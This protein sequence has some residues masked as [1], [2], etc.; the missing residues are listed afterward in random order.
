MLALV[1]DLSG[2]ARSDSVADLFSHAFTTLVRA[3]PFDAGVAAMLE[4]DLDLYVSSRHASRRVGEPLI[5][6][7][8]GALREV[9]PSDFANVDIIVKDERQSLPAD[10]DGELT[11]HVHSILR[12]ENRTVGFVLVTRASAKFNED[13]HRVVDIF[14]AQLS[15]LLDN[16]RARE[17][18][19]S[20]ADIDD[21][22][23]IPNRRHFRRQLTSEM[24]RARV[25]NEPLSVLIID[26][27]D[28]K[29]INDT[30]GHVMGDVVLSELCGTI[31]DSVRVPD[32]V[33]RFGGDEFAV[34]LPHTSASGAAIVADRILKS[35]QEMSIH[36]DEDRP[37]QC[38]VSVGIAQCES[39][40]TNFND[41]VRRA[42]ACL[43]DSKRH[44]KNRYTL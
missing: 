3:I 31:R 9:I 44:G 16:L 28:F 6:R 39:S 41:V 33:S 22:T 13:E 30:Y 2:L 20:L 23:G 11:H 29:V 10:G 36:D 27:D 4:Q 34:L 19:L 38:T 21:L 40:D 7:V 32:A 25:Y 35:V 12:Q 5:E 1:Q 37:I 26:V 43:Y 8:R 15:M 24:Q 17:K 42:D 14:T 18:I